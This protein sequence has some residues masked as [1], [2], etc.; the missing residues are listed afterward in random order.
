MQD[1]VSYAASLAASSRSLAF[2]SFCRKLSSVTP[3]LPPAPVE[4]PPGAPLGAPAYFIAH[5][6]AT[7]ANSSGCLINILATSASCGSL[8]SG[9]ARRDWREI[10]AFFNVMMGDQALLRVSK[11]MA[12][13]PASQ[14]L[15]H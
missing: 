8:G 5:S 14:H 12:P 1:I 4:L 2:S 7:C 9:E 6:L 3:P 11:Q 13:L 10:R 15:Q